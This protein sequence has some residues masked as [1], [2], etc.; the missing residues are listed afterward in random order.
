MKYLSSHFL[1]GLLTTVLFTIGLSSCGY[2]LRGATLIPE[3][4]LP[5]YIFKDDAFHDLRQKLSS[6]LKRSDIEITK[7]TTDASTVIKI[8]SIKKSNNVISVDSLGRTSEIKLGVT[9][10]VSITIKDISYQKKISVFKDV[11]FNPENILSYKK[12]EKILYDEM[13]SEVARLILLQVQAKAK[14]TI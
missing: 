13:F 8:V 10:D 5:I 14:H 2:H 7:N 6:R 1:I 11:A 4:A 3:N 9:V 12:E